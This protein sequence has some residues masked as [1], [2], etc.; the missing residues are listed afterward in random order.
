MAKN[1]D[2][3]TRDLPLHA[4]LRRWLLGWTSIIEIEQHYVLA[5][6]LSDQSVILDL[7]AN[8]GGFASQMI[9]CFGCHVIAIE[10]EKTNFEAIPDHPKLRKLQWAVGGR[11][12]R[13]G[14]SVSADPTGHRL[15]RMDEVDADVV[16]E[17]VVTMHDFPSLIA[18]TGTRRIDLMKVDVEGCEWDWLDT[19]SDQELL[20]IGQLTIEFH[21]FL[22]E[23]RGSNRTWRNYQ[24]LIGL[25]FHCIEDPAFCSYNVLFV[26]RRL[27]IKSLADCVLIPSLGRMLRITWKLQR[28]RRR[29][30]QSA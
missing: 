16:T 12:G 13:F 10:P 5:S 22:P 4:A 1:P 24:R 26:N 11:C 2:R 18:L 20:A 9:A 6:A 14:V 3:D 19:I 27:R 8:V 30:F 17:Q 21:D 15:N 28:L 25:G 29:L 7:G 23:Y